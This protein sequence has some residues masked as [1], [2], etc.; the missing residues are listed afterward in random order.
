M[1]EMYKHATRIRESVDESFSRYMLELEARR[2]ELKLQ[3]Q[4]LAA[5]PNSDF[6]EPVAHY[7]DEEDAADEIDD[8]PATWD[9]HEDD[10]PVRK[11]TTKVNWELRELQEHHEALEHERSEVKRQSMATSSPWWN[12]AGDYTQKDPELSNMRDRARPPMLGNDITFPRSASPEPARFDVTQGSHTLRSQMCYLTEHIEA[13]STNPKSPDGLWMGSN[14]PSARSTQS[15]GL[16][17]GFCVDNGESQTPGLMPPQGPT[18]LLTPA[19]EPANPFDESMFDVPITV[20]RPP[21]PPQSSTSGIDTALHSDRELDQLMETDYPDSFITQVYNYLSLGYP[22]LARPF[23][24][25]LAK[26]SQVP[27][28]DLRHDDEIAKSLPKG[29]IRLGDDFQGR[30]DGMELDDGQACARWRALKKYV[31]EWAKQEK[32]MVPVDALG[33]NWGAGPRRGSWAW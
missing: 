8:R 1:S 25:E 15:Q 33:G 20:S 14:H 9:G 31:R 18:G 7:V 5:F 6:H 28:V 32:G 16:W 12:P 21:T 3:E 4:A 11:G 13:S 29:Y 24:G 30:G 27:V 2:A 22:S 23:D 17:G 26:I 10:M 19:I